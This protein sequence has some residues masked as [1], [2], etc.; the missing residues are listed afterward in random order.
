MLT[1]SGISVKEDIRWASSS[2][3][4]GNWTASLRWTG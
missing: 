1:M 3:W 4:T 2:I